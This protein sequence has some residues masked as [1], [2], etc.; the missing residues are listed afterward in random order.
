MIFGIKNF[1]IKKNRYKPLYK[2]FALLRQNVQNRNKIYKFKR[3]KWQNLLKYLLK[4]KN[5][6]RKFR[7]YDHNIYYKPKFTFYLNNTFRFN[8]QTKKRFNIFYGYF[9]E[10][11]LKNSMKKVLKYF[12]NNKSFNYFLNTKSCFIE[13]LESRIDSILYRSHF[14]LSIRNARQLISHGQ[15]F[16]NNKKVKSSS[17]CV[18]KGDLISI[19]IKSHYL[20]SN[21]LNSSRCWPLPPKYLLINYKTYQIT[22]ISEIKYTNIIFHFPF[23]LDTNS[24]I[25]YYNR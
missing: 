2:K 9:T 24:I 15:V 4:L 18:K 1:M 17:Y 21:C 8:L 20:I 12:K 23:W 11:Y 3:K 6:E 19:N 5:S 7:M 14:V 16:I 22:I 25:K 10:K 13:I